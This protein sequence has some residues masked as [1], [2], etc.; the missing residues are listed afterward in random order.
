MLRHRIISAVIGVPLIF[1]VTWLG[2]IW[3]GLFILFIVLVG[4]L[5]FYKLTISP[6]I[7]T[8]D[9]S[10]SR[11]L[12]CLCLAWSALVALWALISWCT[13]IDFLLATM[14]FAV[15]I[16]LIWTIL[17]SP[18]EKAFHKW[19]WL[20]AGVVYV[21]WMLGYWVNL[22]TLEA[23]RGWV[24]LALFTTFANDTGAFFGGRKWGKHQMAP[25]ISPGKTWEGALSGLLS[26]VFVAVIVNF[27]LGFIETR[28]APYWQIILIG[29]LISIFAQ[30]GDLVESLLKRNVGAKDSGNILPGHGGILDRFDSLIFVGPVVY[31][32]VLWV[33]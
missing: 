19:V 7:L 28:P 20:L 31:Y 33:I 9:N 3:F 30:F 12:T 11:S 13:A 22:Y 26:A 4:T 10:V 17:Q 15:L 14:T 5:E 16:S 27:I 8:G 18:R 29:C 21:G 23:G 2:T 32:Y 1:L 6:S 25:A 24:Y